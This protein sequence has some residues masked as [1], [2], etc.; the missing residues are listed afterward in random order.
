[1]TPVLSRRER[2]RSLSHRRLVRAAAGDNYTVLLF[3]PHVSSIIGEKLFSEKLPQLS[4]VIK[5]YRADIGSTGDDHQKSAP[6]TSH[7]TTDLSFSISGEPAPI[8]TV[9]FGKRLAG[10]VNFIQTSSGIGLAS[11]R[12]APRPR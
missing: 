11:I 1:M 3:N 6:N 8:D 12:L 5:H 7:G 10:V 4:N 9:A 2:N